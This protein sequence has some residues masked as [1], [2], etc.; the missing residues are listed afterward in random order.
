MRTTD[1]CIVRRT[2]LCFTILLV[3]GCNTPTETIVAPPDGG[4]TPPADGGGIDTFYDSHARAICGRLFE[5]PRHTDDDVVLR[6][7]FGTEARCVELGAELLRRNGASDD[8]LRLVSE[9]TVRYD[10]ALA[11]ACFAALRKCG[12]PTDVA[13]IGACREMFDGSVAAGEACYVDEDCAGDAYCASA[14][15]APFAFVC[16]GICRPRKANGASCS[17]ENECAASKGFAACRSDEAGTRCVDYSLAAPVALDQPCGFLE[18]EALTPCGSAAW[19]DGARGSCR[20]E[21]SA[22][23]ACTSQADV[24]ALGF[25]CSEADAGSVCRPMPIGKNA[26]DAC[27]STSNGVCDP[28]LSLFCVAGACAL[29]GD[30]TEGSPCRS[31]DLGQFTCRPGLACGSTTHV[32][33]PIVKT[34]EP[35]EGPAQ[36]ESRSCIGGTC[37]ARRC[38]VH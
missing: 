32:C 7:V 2:I 20:G 21:L 34:G 29:T 30:G 15:D 14:G 16:P 13:E 26:G 3:L 22:G 1:A 17:F 11:S 10:R 37:N 18:R 23:A 36:C 9:G 28:F 4:T 33:K 5:C 19:C 31:S 25:A 12:A 38:G 8:L 6:N 27:E 24:C 35:C